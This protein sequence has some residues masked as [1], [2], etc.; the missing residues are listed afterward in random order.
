[1]KKNSNVQKIPELLEE[2]VNFNN[3]LASWLSHK[4]KNL[5]FLAGVQV[6]YKFSE[7]YIDSCR[8]NN[9]TANQIKLHKAETEDQIKLDNAK[10]KNKMRL[11]DK[12]IEVLREKERCA[13]NEHEREKERQRLKQE[14]LQLS[15]KCH[16]DK[17]GF[18]TPFS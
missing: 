8:E 15:Q 1:M 17:I 9:E 13:H 12:E 18:K 10:T 11:R 6:R 5:A 4:S 3:D 2:P 7:A 16:K 14:V